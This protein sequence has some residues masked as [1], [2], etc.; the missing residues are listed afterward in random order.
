MISGSTLG[1]RGS[2]AG[3]PESSLQVGQPLLL[4][5]PSRLMP[6]SRQLTQYKDTRSLPFR[7]GK[8]ISEVSRPTQPKDQTG[9]IHLL[10]SG[11][12]SAVP[13]GFTFISLC[14]SCGCPHPVPPLQ[15]AGPIC[16]PW[17]RTLGCLPWLCPYG[18]VHLADSSTTRS[19][20]QCT[21]SVSPPCSS[22]VQIRN[23]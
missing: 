5:C 13:S 23:N 8:C 19:K 16:S 7:N 2:T 18:S 10:G 3:S 9:A 17:G 21:L 12:G 1:M 20:P 4:P 15:P 14:G 22:L 6:P 11:Q